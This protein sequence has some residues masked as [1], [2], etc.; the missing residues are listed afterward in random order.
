MVFQAVSVQ[1]RADRHTR[2]S[3]AHRVERGPGRTACLCGSELFTA[4]TIT[5]Q[6]LTRTTTQTH[7]KTHTKQRERAPKAAHKRWQQQ[8]RQTK[9]HSMLVC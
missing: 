2:G 3:S 1:T 6:L 9:R 8:L 4:P 7:T 5:F